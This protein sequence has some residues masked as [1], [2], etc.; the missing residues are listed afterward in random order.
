MSWNGAHCDVPRFCKYLGNAL[1]HGICTIPRQRRFQSFRLIQTGAYT[2]VTRLGLAG[3]TFRAC[4]KSRSGAA[5]PAESIGMGA[6]LLPA[7]PAGGQ[8][9]ASAGVPR[10]QGAD[11]TLQQQV[12]QA[13]R[14]QSHRLATPSSRCRCPASAPSASGRSTTSFAVR[15]PDGTGMILRYQC[16]LGYPR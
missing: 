10:L 3:R 15:P 8:R 16:I 4:V 14:R 6:M 5:G 13:A 11:A 7:V 9:L 1:G 2:G 12:A